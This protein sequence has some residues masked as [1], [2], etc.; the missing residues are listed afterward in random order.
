MR[1][2]YENNEI[3]NKLKLNHFDSKK[4]NRLLNLTEKK[5]NKLHKFD[6]LNDSLKTKQLF[7]HFQSS[8][9][10]PNLDNIMMLK[11][12]NQKRKDLIVDLLNEPFSEDEGESQET[13]STLGHSQYRLR[14][15]RSLK[16]GNTTILRF[17]ENVT[18]FAPN[19]TL[20]LE[21]A[22][23]TQENLHRKKFLNYLKKK[24]DYVE[25]KYTKIEECLLEKKEQ[26]LQKQRELC[27]LKDLYEGGA[28]DPKVM[29][30]LAHLKNIKGSIGDKFKR[31]KSVE[32]REA[33]Q[34]RRTH[35]LYNGIHKIIFNQDI[36]DEIK[37]LFNELDDHKTNTI[38]V[39]KLLLAIR[40]NR[41]LKPFLKKKVIGFVDNSSLADLNQKGSFCILVLSQ[42]I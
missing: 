35:D 13:S 21:S 32:L 15:K 7:S 5:L 8:I 12:K 1:D 20:V 24:I 22:S 40:K 29:S 26:D 2:F 36:F 34:R 39:K 33:S 42:E 4:E 27:Y 10:E 28:I 14:E 18:M 17:D 3:K 37:E 19:E 41:F 31:K 6:I 11:H 38:S 25:P 23:P 9:A 16:S 30:N